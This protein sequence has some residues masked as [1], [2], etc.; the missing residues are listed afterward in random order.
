MI[1]EVQDSATTPNLSRMFREPREVC[2]LFSKIK[3][4]FII[5]I[6]RKKKFQLHH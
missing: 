5:A 1:G 2:L 4:L 6:F 3:N